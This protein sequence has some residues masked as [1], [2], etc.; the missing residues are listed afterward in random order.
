MIRRSTKIALEVLLG[1]TL[2]IVV[3]AGILLWR[4]ASEPVA[5]DFLTPYLEEALEDALPNSQVTIGATQLQWRGWSHSLNLKA[6][7]VRILDADG[8]IGLSLPSLSLRLSTRA[9]AHGIVTPSVVEIHD[10]VL[11]LVRELDG[12]IRLEYGSQ[13]P[14]GPHP[15]GDVG[16]GLWEFLATVAPAPAVE[17]PLSLLNR[18]RILESTILVV[19]KKVDRV[20]RFPL[21]HLEINRDGE[22]I[23]GG[24]SIAIGSD[25]AAAEIDTA[26]IYDKSARIIDLAATFGDLNTKI[27]AEAF[28]ELEPLSVL[29]TSLRG[30][31]SASLAAGEGLTFVRFDIGSGPGVLALQ[32]HGLDDLPVR[33]SRLVG[34]LD[35]RAGRVTFDELM[36]SLGSE[37]DVGPVISVTGGLDETSDLLAGEM[38]GAFEVQVDRVEIADLLGLW[39]TGL[40]DNAREWVG[41]NMTAGSAGDLMATVA[42]HLSED[43]GL[44]V[45]S[46]EGGFFAQEVELHY[47]K[48]LAPITG[49]TGVATFGLDS[50]SF[51]A[52][53]GQVRDIEIAGGQ[54]LLSNLNTTLHTGNVEKARVRLTTNGPVPTA[55][56]LLDH[57]SLDLLTDLGI[58]PDSSTGTAQVALAFDFPLLAEL[59]FEQV[60]L[61][62]TGT[63]AGVGLKD[64]FLGQDVADGE[65]TLDLDRRAMHIVGT[66]GLGGVPLEVDWSETFEGDQDYRTHV[67][68]SVARLDAAARE[69]FGID[70]RDYLEGSVA[71][72]VFL[73]L[74]DGGV[75][76]LKAAVNFADSRLV[77]EPI[78]WE[79]PVGAPAE[80]RFVLALGD[81]RVTDYSRVEIK[82]DDLALSGHAL[83][84]GAGG[85]TKL[86]LDELNF[87]GGGLKDVTIGIGEPQTDIVIGRGWLNAE[88]FLDL[89]DDDD[90]PDDEE[91][92]DPFTLRADTLERV[93]LSEGREL[94]DAMLRLQQVEAGWQRL[95]LRG[96]LAEA[97]R[98]PP[99][100]RRL[101]VRHL[102]TPG[103]QREGE[104]KTPDPVPSEGEDADEKKLA[105]PPDPAVS[106]DF[107]PDAEGRQRLSVVA[108]DFGGI[109]KLFDVSDAVVAGQLRIKGVGDGPYPAHALDLQLRARDFLIVEGPTAEKILSLTSYSDIQTLLEG[110]GLLMRRLMGDLTLEDGK[111]RTDLV[112]L[113]GGELGVTARGQ[114]DLDRDWIQL[115][116]TL[117]PAYSINS[118]L[119]EIPLLG[120]LLVGG[121]GEGILAVVYTV[122]GSPKDPEVRVNPLSVLAPGFLRGL[123][124]GE[125]I[126]EDDDEPPQALPGPRIAPRS[127]AD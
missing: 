113:F 89:D 9:L 29:E 67:K 64:F 25:D 77:L 49:L 18:V 99:I 57:E 14:S 38:R 52:D 114:L 121:E 28:S 127:E 104:G 20:W 102:P 115:E 79:K 40:S 117:I 125:G 46:L 72:N 73:T 32:H 3:P 93:V 31:L 10:A 45:E 26:F 97:L 84:D 96:R 86:V 81:E 80:G 7:G 51:A 100:T 103:R 15:E 21:R 11:F 22:G 63:L 37:D 27:L 42:F 36:M 94:H 91:A 74:Q 70:L 30:S 108:D 116:G 120:P 8:E 75:G 12:S 48:P 34:Q 109:L 65:L 50:L 126:L 2:L 123:F 53:G 111:L 85:L 56:E 60:D 118:I 92:R 107:G 88:Y 1:L 106:I 69:R 122:E 16:L 5:L 19:D 58:R 13:P 61:S 112:R 95:F 39:P 66:L 76:E 41:E 119:G 17:R 4:L 59:E 98:S 83:P 47:F 54:L 62:A 68:A 24:L 71:A 33:S 101:N 55:L 82:A 35:T 78:G 6:E 87:A 90:P 105:V 23:N 43:G 44:N 124:S 110:E